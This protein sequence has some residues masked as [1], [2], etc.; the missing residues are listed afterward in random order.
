MVTIVN[1]IEVFSCLSKEGRLLC[2]GDALGIFRWGERVFGNVTREDVLGAVQV[3]AEFEVV[4]FSGGATIAILSNDQVKDCLGSGHKTKS[5][6]H[7]KELVGGDMELLGSVEVHETGLEKDPL[8][9]D[10]VVHLSDGVHHLVFV[11][12]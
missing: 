8:S 10:F 2:W 9:L 11:L 3:I 12:V 4:D 7:S 6:E 1:N 5:L